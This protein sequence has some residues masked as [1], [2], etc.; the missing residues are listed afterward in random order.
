M[1][2]DPII[3]RSIFLKRPYLNIIDAYVICLCCVYHSIFSDPKRKLILFPVPK[4]IKRFLKTKTEK[5]MASHS[6]TLA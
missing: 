1:K 4:E 3:H 6:G 2:F 5:A